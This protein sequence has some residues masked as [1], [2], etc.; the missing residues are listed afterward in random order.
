[1]KRAV[2]FGTFLALGLSLVVAGG[3]ASATTQSF[4]SPNTHQTFTVPANVTSITLS[5]RGGAGGSG[6]TDGHSGGDAGLHVG[7]VTGTLN[8]TPG[9]VI[10]IYVGGGGGN[11]SG[12]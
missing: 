6:G 4:T 5:M 1:M 8:V 3:S 9:Q 2:V 7:L 12:C 11:G 10:N